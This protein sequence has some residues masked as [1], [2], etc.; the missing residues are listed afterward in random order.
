[1]KNKIVKENEK[2]KQKKNQKT[3]NKKKKG[4]PNC[5]KITTQNFHNKKTHFDFD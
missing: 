1:M 4:F 5:E 3:K 2:K